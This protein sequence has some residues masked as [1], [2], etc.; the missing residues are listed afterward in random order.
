[1]GVRSNSGE[2]NHGAARACVIPVRRLCVLG[3]SI[4]ARASKNR[5]IS[6]HVTGAAGSAV[7]RQAGRCQTAL[8]EPR[9]A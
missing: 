3:L 7:S 8:K 4:F 9:S 2:R 5:S 6:Q 1:M